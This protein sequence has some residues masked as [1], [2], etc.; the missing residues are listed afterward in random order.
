MTR[1]DAHY[2]ST[3]RCTIKLRIAGEFKRWTD[4][5]IRDQAHFHAESRINLTQYCS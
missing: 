4:K 5:A 1:L 3:G 2:H